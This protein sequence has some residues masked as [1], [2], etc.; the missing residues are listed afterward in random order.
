MEKSKVIHYPKGLEISYKI[1]LLRLI[2]AIESE[3]YKGVNSILDENFN[4]DD[5]LDDVKIFFDRLSVFAKEKVSLII[6]GLT[7]RLINVVR[8][9]SNQVKNSLRD[10]EPY[11][12]DLI[13][14]VEGFDLNLVNQLLPILELNEL[15]RTSLSINIQLV[16]SIPIELLEDLSYIIEDGFRSRAS[17]N[18]LNK[19]ITSKFNISRNRASVIARTEIAK[20]HSNTIRDEYLKLGMENYEWYTSNDERVR[21]SHKVLNKKIC[22]WNDPT[23]YKNEITDKTWKKKSSI[24][25]VEK[26]VGEDF[27]CRCSIIAILN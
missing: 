18:E 26:Q 15:V 20:L 22:N 27:Q 8:L 11:R 13:D 17:L 14:N 4:K 3:F 21:S 6:V 23:I 19:S 12:S 25:A 24:S 16:K 2:D 5:F 1:E 9:A 10:I 7:P